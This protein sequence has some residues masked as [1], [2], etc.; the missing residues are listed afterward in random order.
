MLLK[1][2]FLGNNN[3]LYVIGCINPDIKKY[4]ITLYTLID[5]YKLTHLT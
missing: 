3:K 4:D 1:S 5:V 2:S